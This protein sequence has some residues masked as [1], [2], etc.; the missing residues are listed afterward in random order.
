MVQ[1]VLPLALIRGE[2]VVN[3]PQDLFIPP[4]ALEVILESFE[5]PLDLLLYLI[6]KQKF[7]ILDMPIAPITTQYMQYIE[8]MKEIKM[9]LAAEYLVMAA[10]LMEIKSRLLLPKQAVVEEDEDPRA[11]LVRR[12]QEYEVIKN[13]AQQLDGIPRLERN[14]FQASVELSEDFQTAVFQAD[15]ELNEL[16]SALQ[17]ILKRTKALEHHRI[18]KEF[19][20]TR[21]RMSA[22]L[23]H[24]K[25]AATTAN[26]FVEFSAL[27]SV[28]EGRQGVVVTFLAILELIKESLIECMQTTIFGQL[29]VRLPA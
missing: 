21:E 28:Q 19:L 29:R 3:K 1:Q 23:A 18:E 13:A 6:R 16:V 5:G 11:E 14:T 8:L 10:I 7:D 24:L 22:I 4:D 20:S 9:E 25:R 27:F 15:V 2:V 26:A 17:G 12:L